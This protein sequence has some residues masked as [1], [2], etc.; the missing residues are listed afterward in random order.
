[1]S[2]GWIDRKGRTLI[3]FLVN[4]SVGTMFVKSVDASDYAK[5]G[6][7]L[8]ELL[9]TFFEEMSEKN[10]VHLITDNGSNYVADKILTHNSPT[11]FGLHVLSI[12]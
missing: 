8:A 6:E 3:N 5:T 10:V 7:K 1:M 9:D 4:S 2:D 12:V 11:C